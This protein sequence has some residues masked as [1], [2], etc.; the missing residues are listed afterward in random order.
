MGDKVRSIYEVIDVAKALAVEYKQLT[1]KP[2]GISGEVAE[3]EAHRL[4]G[5]ELAPARTPGYDAV[6]H[7]KE[8]IQI[9]GRAVNVQ[10]PRVGRVPRI[11]LEHEFHSVLLVLIDES[12]MEP[13]EIWEAPRDSVSE[14]LT[15]PGSKARN[16]RGSLGIA[17]FCTIAKRVWRSDLSVAI[18]SAKRDR[19]ESKVAA[20][21]SPRS[22]PVDAFTP[23]RRE[24]WKR[25]VKDG[26]F[27]I[28]LSDQVRSPDGTLDLERL[29]TVARQW[30]INERYDHLNPGM[31]RMNIGNRL[32]AVVPREVY[33]PSFKRTVPSSGEGA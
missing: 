18:E 29:Y 6:R 1:G 7:P 15:A 26:P 8:L 19:L 4:L 20:R 12:T 30:G 11:N 17:Q 14:R 24:R 21:V 10:H 3:I 28:W 9:K 16:L 13:Y 23:E 2:L 5:L 22:A 25:L 31:A 33:E 32:R 27:N